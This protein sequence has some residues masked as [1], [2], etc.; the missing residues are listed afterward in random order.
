MVSRASLWFSRGEGGYAVKKS[1]GFLSQVLSHLEGSWSLFLS[2]IG[3]E[4]ICPRGRS[5]G[6]TM[7]IH[8]SHPKIAFSRLLSL[9]LLT[10]F[11]VA[12]SIPAIAQTS[13]QG[14]LNQRD[15]EARALSRMSA[16]QLR[17]YFSGLRELEQRSSSQRLAR[18]KSLESCL[19]RTRQRDGADE[20]LKDARKT[21]RQEREQFV[22]ELN[23]LRSRYKMP[24]RQVGHSSKGM[25]DDSADL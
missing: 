16:P 15:Q 25:A 10:G 20:C 22:R 12:G 23:A 19:E 5:S 24:L 8:H 18:L 4:S 2:P 9:G 11:A 17:T 3:S 7:L 14:S 1:L 21:R 6:L 13:Q